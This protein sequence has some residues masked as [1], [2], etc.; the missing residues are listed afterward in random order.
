MQDLQPLQ[1]PPAAERVGNW[2][3]AIRRRGVFKLQWM[4]THR[5]RQME[6]SDHDFFEFR[7]K[8]APHAVGVRPSVALDLRPPPASPPRMFE[9]RVAAQRGT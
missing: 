8:V 5:V 3:G 6:L 7:F 4:W 1:L 2:D 9:P